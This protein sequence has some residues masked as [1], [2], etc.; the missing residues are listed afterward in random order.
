MRRTTSPAGRLALPVL[1]VVLAAAGIAAMLA[2]GPAGTTRRAVPG[3][4]PAAGRV[5]DPFAWTPRNEASLVARAARG[6]SHGIYAL[7][8]GGVEASAGR[9][10]HWRGLVDAAAKTAGVDPDTLEGLVLLESAGRT[11]AVTPSGLDGA[12]GLTQILAQTGRDLLGMHVDVNAAQRLSN[13]IQK[14]TDRGDSA[15]VADLVRRRAQAD[16]RF[17]ARSSL[18]ATARYLA[19]ARRRFGREDLAIVSYH[20]GQGN[21]E[22]VLRDYTGSSNGSIAALVRDDHLSYGRVYFDSTPVRHAAAWRRLSSLGDDSAN[23]LWKV[24]AARDVMRLWRTNRPA[25]R[26]EAALQTAADTAAE[27]LHPPA[28]TPRFADPDALKTAWDDRALAALPDRPAITGLHVDPAMGRGTS[29]PAQHRGLRPAALAVALYVGAQVRALAHG[30]PLTVTETVRDG[31]QGGGGEDADAADMHSAGWAFDIAR[32]Y[33][34]VTQAQ[35]FQFVLDRLSVL[36]AIAWQR[37]GRRIHVTAANERELLGLLRRV[38][39][40]TR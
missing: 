19:Q 34:S 3:P 24:L 36:D 9:T 12:V 15:K 30:S 25:L 20:M 23:Y 35:A 8:P 22:S 27:A 11:D 6:T 10:A 13:R 29:D 39:G 18:Q 16:Q 21:L 31:T 14:A 1:A 4:G 5:A 33:S 32:T 26:R 38:G 2:R 7:S 28:S 40:S 17:D 37:I